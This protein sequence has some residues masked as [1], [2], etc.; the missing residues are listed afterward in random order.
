[1]LPSITSDT[2]ITKLPCSNIA[3]DGIITVL[4]ST[5]TSASIDGG[6]YAI[7]PTQF[8]GLS[9]GSHTIIYK[10]NFGCTTSSIYNLGIYPP[11]T[12][13]STISHVN[14]Y[15]SST[16]QININLS[17]IIDNLRLSFINPTG[18]YVFNNV[19]V[20]SS[21][22]V[23][24]NLAT[25]SWTASIFTN[26][27]NGCQNYYN[28]FNITS[29]APITFTTTA[30]YIDSCSNQIIFNTSGGLGGYTYFAQ[31][32]DTG[33]SY[34]TTGSTLSTLSLNG[35]VFTVYV[36]DTGSC[37]SGF[38]TQEVY[39]RQYVYSGSYCDTGSV[40][41]TTT[42]TVPPTTT[43]CT[44]LPPFEGYTYIL[45]DIGYFNSNNA[46]SL[47][48]NFITVYRNVP[49]IITGNVIYNDEECTVPIDGDNL[50]WYITDIFSSANQTVQINNIGVIT[51]VVTCTTPKPNTSNLTLT[52]AS[53][54][55]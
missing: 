42:T 41:T 34:S 49:S 38:K 14:C 10:N 3:T 31:E 17:N 8:T 32:T 48:E 52:S 46:C 16:G 29:S 15:G 11:L 7:L 22:L 19:P 40:P 5:A 18:S 51:S 33:A 28:T 4:N 36:Q 53:Q 2:V 43:T 50:W 44:T 27:I 26:D 24:S 25:G 1:M 54:S 6:S 37:I 23:F 45:S 55:P 47:P 39:G 35:G 21:T 30:S 20:T 12:A 13:S 9:T